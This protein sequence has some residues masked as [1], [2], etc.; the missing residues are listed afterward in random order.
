MIGPSIGYKIKKPSDVLIH[1][2]RML[3]RVNRAFLDHLSLVES[4]T[5]N[6]AQVL[7][8]REG[9]SEPAVA[10]TPLPET[11]NLDEFIHDDVFEWARRRTSS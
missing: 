6:E 5:W 9:P 4:P 3:R 11:P 2:Q 1:R 7:A 8:V 10:D